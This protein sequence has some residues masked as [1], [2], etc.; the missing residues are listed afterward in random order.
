[1]I[2][3]QLLIVRRLYN[4][5]YYFVSL[6]DVSF[7]PQM[8]V[9]IVQVLIVAAIALPPSLHPLGWI[10]YNRYLNCK[11][12]SF[13]LP[14]RVRFLDYSS[15]PSPIQKFRCILNI[16][17]Y[18]YADSRLSFSWSVGILIW[19]FEKTGGLPSS[20]IITVH[21]DLRTHTLLRALWPIAYASIRNVCL[22]SS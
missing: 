6:T 12:L 7:E 4:D 2:M 17:N 20:S 13:L 9:L 19:K 5:R 22:C 14:K 3:D 21:A 10:I 11:I 18:L 15:T 16:L 1:M 8:S